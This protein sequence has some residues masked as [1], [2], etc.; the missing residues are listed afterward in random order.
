VNVGYE[1]GRKV[2]PTFRAWA[3]QRE[4]HEQYIREMQRVEPVLIPAVVTQPVSVG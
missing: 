2:L 3:A 1:A 4:L